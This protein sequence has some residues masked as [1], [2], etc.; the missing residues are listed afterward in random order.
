MLG[1]Y[2]MFD[3]NCLEAIE[4]YKKA[5]GATVKEMRQ[6]KDMP[7]DPN[8]PVSEEQKELVL[9]AMLEINGSSV[10]CADAPQRSVS[11]KNM[12]ITLTTPDGA[13]VTK[14]WDVLKVDAEI[15]MDLAPTFFAQLHGS[16]Q[17]KFGVNWMFTV[18]AADV[19]EKKVKPSYRFK[20]E[21]SPVIFDVNYGG[22]QA[23]AQF[24]KNKE[25]VI[26]K[27]A[28]LAE[29]VPLN[30]DGTVGF[31]AKAALGLRGEHEADI[32]DFVTTADIVLKSPH[33]A[34]L[35]LYFGGT[36]AWLEFKDETGKPIHAYCVTNM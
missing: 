19:P 13:V 25:F 35:F 12:L 2:L 8:F 3:G 30:K 29:E 24:R 6:Y 32:T 22:A 36:N 27:G 20:K 11:G 5:F 21:V 34:G 1:H 18:R 17:D 26:F 33:E 16:L 23:K 4:L 10:M 28:K 7:E 9:N 14:A 15:T 31:G